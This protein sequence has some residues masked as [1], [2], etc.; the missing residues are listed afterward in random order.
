M[1]FVDASL[2]FFWRHSRERHSRAIS[3]AFGAALAFAG[4]CDEE[5]F[6]TSAETP[7]WGNGQR[8]R[9]ASASLR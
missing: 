5:H 8:S 9:V 6:A 1:W 7:I 3:E 2:R 4:R